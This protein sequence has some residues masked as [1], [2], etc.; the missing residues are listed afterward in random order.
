MFLP[1]AWG[2]WV[3][4]HS[5]K[6]RDNMAM[7]YRGFALLIDPPIMK[8]PVRIDEEPLFRRGCFC[9]CVQDVR[10]VY[11]HILPRGDGIEDT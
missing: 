7:R 9:E 6:D 8:S 3:T 2:F 1:E 11:Q 5:A 10:A 4:L